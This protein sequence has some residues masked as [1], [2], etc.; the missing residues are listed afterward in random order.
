[1]V[2]TCGYLVRATSA[3]ATTRRVAKRAGLPGNWKTWSVTIRFFEPA[4]SFSKSPTPLT[5]QEAIELVKTFAEETRG[6][7][8][9]DK[10]QALPKKEIKRYAGNIISELKEMLATQTTD[11]KRIL[12]KLVETSQEPKYEPQDF[13]VVGYYEE[14]DMDVLTQEQDV[15]ATAAEQADGIVDIIYYSLDRAVRAGYNLDPIFREVHASNMSK[16]HE[17][18]K[19]HQDENGKITKPKHFKEADVLSIIKTH[20]ETGAW[21]PKATPVDLLPCKSE[22]EKLLTTNQIHFEWFSDEDNGMK[23]RYNTNVRHE[24]YFGR[25]LELKSAFCLFVELIR[26]FTLRGSKC[27]RLQLCLHRVVNGPVIL[28]YNAFWA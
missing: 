26:P 2:C 5:M 23:W 21:T 12:H 16:K 13:K 10:P 14:L 22:L 9:P 3:F 1:M 25:E 15:A 27:D 7:P 11:W 4:I 19:Y 17:D 20:L 6:V 8:C 24:D 28:Y 18:G